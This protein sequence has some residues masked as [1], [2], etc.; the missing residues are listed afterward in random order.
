MAFKTF[1]IPFRLP[2]LR[3]LVGFPY[4]GT[5]IQAAR[6]TFDTDQSVCG[7]VRHIGWQP[8]LFLLLL[9]I[10]P[11]GQQGILIPIL[12]K[13]AAN[14]LVVT[15][16]AVWHAGVHVKGAN[17]VAVKGAFNAAAQLL[18]VAKGRC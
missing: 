13:P 2:Q 17:V 10:A 6:E 16:V 7:G 18:L 8:K 11:S 3:S 9:A 5:V 12:G 14:T 15:C 4:S 1:K